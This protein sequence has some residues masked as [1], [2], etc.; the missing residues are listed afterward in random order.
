MLSTTRPTTMIVGARTSEE[1]THKLL[2]VPAKWLIR[3]L[4]E[5]LT[6]SDIPD[7]NSGLRA[8]RREVSLP[9]LRLLP[10][11]FSC[12]T[13]I[14]LGV[15]VQPARHP[16]RADRR[17]RSEPASRSSTSSRTPTATSCRCCAWSCTSTRSRSSCR[18]ALFLLTPSVCS[19]ACFDMVAHSGPVRGQ[20]RAH[21]HH[22]CGDRCAR[23]A[24]RPDRAVTL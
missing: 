3:K 23:A 9:Y 19:R 1:G 22:R 6:N 11:G 14:T 21:L 12:V 16:L 7:L 8:F 20:H 15:P 5:K 18:L 4:A 13:T 17:T 10:P 24:G 2:R